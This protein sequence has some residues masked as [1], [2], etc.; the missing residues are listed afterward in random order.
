M[1]VLTRINAGQRSDVL[2]RSRRATKKG[3]GMAPYAVSFMGPNKEILVEEV[4]WFA[5]DDDALDEIG[6]S[7]HPHE[8]QVRQGERMVARF[9]PWPPERQR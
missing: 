1:G 7:K 8:I 4:R 3:V 6:R 5:H 9:P 2:V